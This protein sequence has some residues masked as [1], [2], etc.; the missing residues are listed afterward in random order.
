MSVI[1]TASTL[2]FCWNHFVPLSPGLRVASN[3]LWQVPWTELRPLWTR[4][5]Q[6]CGERRNS[7]GA[8]I[9]VEGITKNPHNMCWFFWLLRLNL[10]HGIGAKHGFYCTVCAHSRLFTSLSI[11]VEPCVPLNWK[12]TASCTLCHIHYIGLHN[13]CCRVSWRWVFCRRFLH[14]PLHKPWMLGQLSARVE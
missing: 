2:V 14:Q 3:R 9:L 13:Y 12:K 8:L 1:V 11:M 10:S 5:V 6:R 7:S 4:F